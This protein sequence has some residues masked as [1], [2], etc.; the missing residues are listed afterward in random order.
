MKWILLKS[1]IM[2]FQVLLCKTSLFQLEAQ[3]RRVVRIRKGIAQYA[4][5]STGSTLYR[6]LLSIIGLKHERDLSNLQQQCISTA[7][8]T[9]KSSQPLST[10]STVLEHQQVVSHRGRIPSSSSRSRTPSSKRPPYVCAL[11]LLVKMVYCKSSRQTEDGVR[12]SKSI[13]HPIR[14]QCTGAVET[15]P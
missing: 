8:Q 5:L 3:T 2:W 15:V 4:C 12:S 10:H 1:Y 11:E 9:P 6:V 14:H 7:T 13:N